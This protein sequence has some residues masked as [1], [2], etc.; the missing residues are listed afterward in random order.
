MRRANGRHAPSALR[1]WL[2]FNFVGL[3]GVGVQLAMLEFLLAATG[4]DTRIATLVAVETTVLHNFC[5]HLRY[6]WRDRR[7]DSVQ[8][9][10]RRLIEFHLT[11]GA[12]SLAGSWTLMTLLVRHERMPVI[13]ANI[14][15][16]AG[17]SVV[18]FLLA[19]I[20]VFRTEAGN[21]R[22]TRRLRSN[23]ASRIRSCA[24]FDLPSTCTER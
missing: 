4:L 16:I 22:K 23:N 1:R 14:V 10:M 17:C 5:W 21:S 24:S 2:R 18:N 15:S 6:T 12:V 7:I 20:L 13:A 3:I 8:L 9:V 19:E 11:N